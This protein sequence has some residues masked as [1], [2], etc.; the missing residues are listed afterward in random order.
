MKIFIKLI[1]TG[2][3]K[4]EKYEMAVVN[5]SRNNKREVDE[6]FIQLKYFL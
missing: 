3:T 4:L 5:N 6:A 1:I 2:K